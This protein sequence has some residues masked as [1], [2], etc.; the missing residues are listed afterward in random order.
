M[1]T[2][3]IRSVLVRAYSFTP[4]RQAEVEEFSFDYRF[5]LTKDESISSVEFVVESGNLELVGEPRI[6]EGRI[7]SQLVSGG[8]IGIVAT[9][10]CVI[11][12]TNGRTEKTE[13]CISILE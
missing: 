6:V 3:K 8:T 4:K 9:L 11:Q 12:T 10:S 2:H 1:A 7:V 13:G 5:W